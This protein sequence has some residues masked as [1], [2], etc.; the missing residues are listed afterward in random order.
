M[1]RSRTTAQKQAAVPAGLRLFI[2]RRI[3]ELKGLLLLGVLACIT[4]ILAT[5]SAADPSWSNADDGIASNAFGYTG[6]VVADKLVSWLALANAVLLA[7]PA[8]WAIVLM[9]HNKLG[10]WHVRGPAYIATLLLASALLSFFPL[11]GNW[12]IGPGLGGAAGDALASLLTA[13]PK[14][15]LYHWLANA[16]AMLVCAIFCAWMA[17]LALGI[18]P[19]NIVTTIAA[20]RQP[21]ARLGS[22]AIA[23]SS[24]V[25]QTVGSL[26]D[27]YGESIEVQDAL[28]RPAPARKHEPVL[29]ET[30]VK[31]GLIA[32][33]RE[34]QSAKPVSAEAG[35]D[36]P[37][38][39]TR[40]AHLSDNR[41]EPR[42][43]SSAS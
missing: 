3:M 1:P 33:L 38:F 21:T 6:A 41:I 11:P 14:L 25:A 12:P 34:R 8:F 37:A 4:V 5:W 9:S 42:L 16:L 18:S 39:L 23:A 28:T 26:R 40:R 30:P 32:R 24:K 13:L 31:S 19:R 27:R 36:I 10:N 2:W 20:M 22:K 15:F 7:I 17:C 43:S 35:D 29:D